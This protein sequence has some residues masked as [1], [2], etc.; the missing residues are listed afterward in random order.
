MAISAARLGY[1]CAQAGLY[2]ALAHP[3]IQPENIRQN[4]NDQHTPWLALDVGYRVQGNLS[5]EISCGIT[6]SLSNQS[7]SRFMRTQGE[8][9]YHE[10]A[11]EIEERK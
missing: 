7:M 4:R 11:G 3:I 1:C 6:E 10:P 8:Q 5:A 9:K 2:G